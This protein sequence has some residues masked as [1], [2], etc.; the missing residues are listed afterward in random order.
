MRQITISGELLAQNHCSVKTFRLSAKKNY[1]VIP[2]AL[3]EMIKFATCTSNSYNFQMHPSDDN[4][5][6]SQDTLMKVVK[7]AESI[8][9]IS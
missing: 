4:K 7:T 2:V 1:S 3:S 6:P 8:G 5:K 9:Q